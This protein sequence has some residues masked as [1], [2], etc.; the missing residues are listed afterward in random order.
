[1][2]ILIT[3]EINIQEMAK[4]AMTLDPITIKRSG[5]INDIPNC[6]ASFAVFALIDIIIIEIIDSNIKIGI[7]ISKNIKKLGLG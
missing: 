5:K 7:N 1:M 4:K 3:I 2:K 6:L